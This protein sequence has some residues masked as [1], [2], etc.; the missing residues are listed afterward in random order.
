ME[1]IKELIDRVDIRT[2]ISNDFEL[3]DYGTYSKG[4]IHDSLVVDHSKNYF[5]WNSIEI[6]GNALDWLT[7]IKG[8]TVIEAIKEL[9]SVAGEL[10]KQREFKLPIEINIYPK[11]LDIFYE[12]GKYHREYWYSK[13]YDDNTI[14]RFRLGYTGRCYTIPIIFDDKLIN[15]QC[16]VPASNESP[17]RIWSWSTGLGVLPF[18]FD[19]LHSSSSC[20]IIESPGDAINIAQLGFTAI[21]QTGGSNNWN[22]YWNQFLIN[23]KEIIICYDNDEAGFLGAIRLARQFED[24]VKILLWPE[25]QYRLK[26]G[27]GDFAKEFPQDFLKFI[28]INSYPLKIIEPFIKLTIEQYKRSEKKST[29]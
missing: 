18:N 7:E 8:M 22:K 20:F 15:F 27:V 9:K 14:D 4:I 23:Q 13:G 17:K 3:K 12:L 21:S 24:R 2:I 1:R 11:L 29:E 25:N 16:K 5:Y 28:I 19:S 26:Y 6:K 10:P